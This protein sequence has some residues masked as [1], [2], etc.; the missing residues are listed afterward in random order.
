MNKRKITKLDHLK[1]KPFNKYGKSIKGWSWHKISFDKKNEHHFFGADLVKNDPVK[2]LK[3]R[4]KSEKK[5]V[6]KTNIR[7]NPYFKNFI[8]TE[9]EFKKLVTNFNNH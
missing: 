9:S 2:Y 6:G 8:V 5:H 7:N 1:F 4:N 3:T